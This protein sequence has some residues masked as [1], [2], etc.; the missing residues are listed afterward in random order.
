MSWFRPLFFTLA[1]LMPVLASAQSLDGT[2][3]VSFSTRDTETREAIVKIAGAEG[4]WTSVAQLAR[5]RHDPCVGRPFPLL[6]KAAEPQRVR[7]EVAFSSGTSGCKDRTVS[8]Q[9]EGAGVVTG[10]LENGKPLR[11]VRQ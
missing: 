6:V 1:G 10:K 4:T 3:L 11:M 2:W 8:G 5:E 7:L 9:F